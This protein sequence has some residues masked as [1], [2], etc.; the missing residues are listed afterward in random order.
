MMPPR[1]DPSGVGQN[2]PINE[3]RSPMMIA[4][5]NVKKGSLWLVVDGPV[6]FWYWR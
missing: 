2:L 5:G 6:A 1:R 4:I 3:Q